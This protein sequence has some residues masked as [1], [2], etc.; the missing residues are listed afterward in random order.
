[1]RATPTTVTFRGIHSGTAGKWTTGASNPNSSNTD[2]DV[3]SAYDLGSNGFNSL[4]SANVGAEDFFG[5]HYEA[6]AEI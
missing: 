6:D 5:G 3:N 2:Y 1:M 4:N